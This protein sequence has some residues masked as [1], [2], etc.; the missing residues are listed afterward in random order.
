MVGFEFVSPHEHPQ[1]GN[2]DMNG[3]VLGPDLGDA[4]RISDLRTIVI[5]EHLDVHLV[6][7]FEGST[8]VDPMTKNFVFFF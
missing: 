4:A 5:C 7:Y 8:H 3:L 2:A 6:L 1:H